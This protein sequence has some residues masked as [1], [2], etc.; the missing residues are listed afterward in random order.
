MKISELEKRLEQIKAKHGDIEVMFTD[1][2]SSY[3]PYAASGANVEVSD[4]E[5]PEEY[6][7]PKGFTFI[8]LSSW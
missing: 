6:D 4:G 3:G 5:Y 7:M 2:N 8:N 1:P